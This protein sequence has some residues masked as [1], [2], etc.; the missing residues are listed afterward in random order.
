M[1]KPKVKAQPLGPLE[2]A[3]MRVLWQT[4][5]YSVRDLATALGDTHA[6]T[7]VMT[8]MDRLFKKGLLVRERAG[9]AFHYQAALTVTD[10]DR[11]LVA[12]AMGTILRRSGAPALSAFVDAAAD[13]DE[14]HLRDLEQLVATRL[15]ARGKGKS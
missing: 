3:V 8:T 15:G 6:Y 7:T 11:L 4:G 14:R 12:E 13:I 9:A 1:R 2:A 10:F 5:T